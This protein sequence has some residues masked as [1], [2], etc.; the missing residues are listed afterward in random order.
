MTGVM[1]LHMFGDPYSNGMEESRAGVTQAIGRTVRRPKLRPR[2]SRVDEKKAE[3][4]KT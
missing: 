1:W 4:Q 3:C 2:L